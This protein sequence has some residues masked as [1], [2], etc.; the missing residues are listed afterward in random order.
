MGVPA[1]YPCSIGNSIQM[2]FE[3]A[4]WERA[5]VQG[6]IPK[7]FKEDQLWDNELAERFR[8]LDLK[9]DDD[10]QPLPAQSYIRSLA[11]RRVKYFTA[12]HIKDRES[13]KCK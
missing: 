3:V 12:T 13:E 4:R 10:D 11:A 7:I 6:K 8:G 2:K 1:K 9:W 5:V